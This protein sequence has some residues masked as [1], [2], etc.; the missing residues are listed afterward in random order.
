MWRPPAVIEVNEPAGGVNCPRKSL[1]QQVT[2]ASVRIPQVWSAPA[3][4]EVNEPSGGVD[5]PS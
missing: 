2:V 4:I 5:S 3:V 1:P